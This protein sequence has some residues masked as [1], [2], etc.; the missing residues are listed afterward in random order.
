MD[1]KINRT[2]SKVLNDIPKAN[3]QNISNEMSALAPMLGKP[4]CPHCGGVG[5]LRTDVPVGHEKFGRLEPC[6]CRA[7]E[8]AENARNRLYEMSNLSRL[9]HLTFENFIN[10][11]NPKAEFITP[12][13]VASLSVAFETSKAFA[14]DLNG[15]LLLQ[16]S[17]GSGKT[18]LAAAIANETVRRG[19]PTL[20]I[21]V[22]DLLDSL[23]YSFSDPETS[24][25]ARF[26]EIRNAAFLVMDDF[27][28][29]NA[30]PWA[31]EKLFQIINNRYINKLPTV[32]TTNLI[33]DEIESRIRS[34]L[35]DADFVKNI[36]I[37]SPDYRRP[38]E[39]SNPDIS[40]LVL[41]YIKEMTFGNFDFRENELGREIVTTVSK[42]RQYYGNRRKEINII[43]DTVTANGL[44]SLQDAFHTAMNF[45]EKPRVWLV[46]LG[47]PYCGKTH[48]AASIG[49]FHIASGG[50]AIMSDVSSLL[51]YLKR[52]FEQDLDITFYRRYYEISNTPLLILD[53]LQNSGTHS[54]WAEDK[55]HHLLINRFNAQL[56]TILTSSLT[57]DEFAT[58]H[59]SLWNRMLDTTSSTVC[60]I[61]MPPY[62]R[63]FKAKKS[64]PA[65]KSK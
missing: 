4:D 21:T 5:F 8:I 56:P 49:N 45:A 38:K 10:T 18:H 63:A 51:D 65:K 16:G 36:R 22:P 43:R 2:L 37:T 58:N 44:K 47:Q 54:M 12:Q 40:M 1:K 48:L 14:K 30:T 9:S 19:V 46:I 7:N 55:L 59:P 60:I 57:P 24:Y 41:P 15:W 27:G 3:S 13:D 17:Y 23:R 26:E 53:E 35:Q 39:T 6:V 64:P 62:R 25:E 31:Q 34:R 61:D 42:E 20:F 50:Q 28:T 33:L 11:G 32:I 29:H 52:T